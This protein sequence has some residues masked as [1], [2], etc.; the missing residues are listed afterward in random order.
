MRLFV[1]VDP[2]EQFRLELAPWLDTHREAVD[3]RWVRPEL[4]HITLRFLGDW[5]HEHLDSLTEALSTTA[6][7]TPQFRACPQPPDVFSGHGKPQVL[8]LPMHSDG[9]LEHIAAGISEQLKI[10]C[11]GIGAQQNRFRAHVTLGRV[12]R[13]PPAGLAGDLASLPTP[14]LNPFQVGELRL[15]E[16]VLRP[17]GPEY[18]VRHL[19]PLA[20]E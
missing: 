4:M 12:R 1:A 9:V 7:A 10:R 17:D 14:V 20:G 2:G 3:L 15:I 5:P 16:S 11:A 13:N 19:F 8:F 18:H 6:K